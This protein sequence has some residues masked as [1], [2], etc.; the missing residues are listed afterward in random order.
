MWYEAENLVIKYSHKIKDSTELKKFLRGFEIVWVYLALTVHGVLVA[1]G[2]SHTGQA[3]LAGVT[4]L[5][6]SWP[7]CHALQSK[8]IVV[9]KAVGGT[10]LGVIVL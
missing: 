9:D 1:G 6:G 7:R 8:V 2:T 10:G 3:G 5:G 4:G